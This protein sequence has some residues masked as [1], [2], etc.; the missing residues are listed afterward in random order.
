MANASRVIAPVLD[1]HVEECAFLHDQ[2]LDLIS[3][4]HVALRHL[5]R[6]DNRLAAHVD[7]LRVAGD[8]GWRAAQAGLAREGPSALFGPVLMA[9]EGRRTDRLEQLLALAEAVPDMHPGLFAAFGWISPQFL[10]GTIKELLA[11]PSA[12]RR[13]VGIACCAMQRVDPGQALEAAMGDADAGVRARALRAAGELGR[14]DLLPVCGERL[15]DKSDPSVGFWAAWSMA[16]LGDRGASVA[17]LRALAL[18][19]EAA[20]AANPYTQSPRR[21]ALQL[22]LQL[23]P[24][25]EAHELL[26]TLRADPANLRLL[27]GGAGLAG[28]AAY[29]PWMV[30]QMEDPALTRLAG[31]SFS[32]ITGLDLAYLDLDKKPPEGDAGPDEAKEALDEDAHLP[33]PDVSKIQ[34]WWNANAQRFTP[35]VRFFMGEPVTPA[36]ARQVL[37]DGTQRQRRAAALHRCLLEPATAPLFEWRAPVWRQKRLLMKAA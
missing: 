21:R 14:G 35:G 4:P 24:V 12:F 13:R 33:W 5:E 31:E 37:A 26:K 22:L 15:N 7:G 36:H 1:Q 3:A 30:K 23:L 16:L 28:D 32:T 29:V 11:S 10:Q 27:L 6:H 19:P 2:R 20:E 34:A 9:L 25:G 18:A 8:A 17:A